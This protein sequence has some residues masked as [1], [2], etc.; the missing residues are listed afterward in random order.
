MAGAIYNGA[1][2][3]GVI[4]GKGKTSFADGSK[5]EG[6][7]VDGQRHGRGAFTSPEGIVELREWAHG[8]LVEPSSVGTDKAV[9]T[10]LDS[11]SAQS[12]PSDPFS[13]SSRISRLRP[14][15]RKFPT[16]RNQMPM[17]FGWH[18]HIAGKAMRKANASSSSAASSRRDPDHI[19]E[20]PTNRAIANAAADLASWRVGSGLS[21]NS[22][23]GRVGSGLSFP[24]SMSPPSYAGAAA[25]MIIKRAASRPKSPPASYRPR[26]S[27]S[28]GS[29]GGLAEGGTMHLVSPD[30]HQMAC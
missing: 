11:A 18:S 6:T 3:N 30:D 17:P 12:T 28:Q 26:R 16:R 7:Y 10:E 9:V 22:H 2:Q 8:K 1:F 20:T 29:R 21:V 4:E 5:Y 27:E 15:G 13:S 19:F 23:T 25:T 14:T 24:S